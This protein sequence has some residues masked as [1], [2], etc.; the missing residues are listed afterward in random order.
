MAEVVDEALQG[1][2]PTLPRTF[3]LTNTHSTHTR[4]DRQTA[5]DANADV[6]ARM[7]P[8]DDMSSTCYR[9]MMAARVP[10]QDHNDYCFY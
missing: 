1:P 7:H 5:A 10:R 6:D 4:T 3:T 2:T 9:R 8:A